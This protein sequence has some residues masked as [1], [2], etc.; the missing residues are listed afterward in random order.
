[1]DIRFML[2]SMLAHFLE[3][4]RP[5]KICNARDPHVIYCSLDVGIP[6]CRGPAMPAQPTVPLVGLYYA[7]LK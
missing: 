5:R 3:E 1:M 2:L 6:R 4:R 7:I